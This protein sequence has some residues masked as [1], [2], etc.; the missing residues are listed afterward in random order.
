M[1][2]LTKLEDRSQQTVSTREHT[3]VNLISAEKTCKTVYHLICKMAYSRPMNVHEL[4]RAQVFQKAWCFLTGHPN[5][6]LS[7]VE[8]AQLSAFVTDRNSAWK[9]H[10]K[11]AIR[12]LA[13]RRARTI[14]YFMIT[15][16]NRKLN[17]GIVH[18]T[19][20][21]VRPL[22]SSRTPSILLK[23]LRLCAFSICRDIKK[24]VS[25]RHIGDK[26]RR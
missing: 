26:D 4:E 23:W 1:V 10:V 25:W 20:I 21:K 18:Q 17:N 13:I 5:C 2:I 16:Q 7:I 15:M 19:R 6:A 11:I 8:K 22:L 14:E 9:R 12:N 24:C 3:Q